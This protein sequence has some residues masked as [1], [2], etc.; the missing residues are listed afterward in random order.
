MGKSK[1]RVRRVAQLF[2][3]KGHVYPVAVGKY[4]YVRLLLYTQ[5][6]GEQSLLRD[7]LGGQTVK[8]VGSRV[9]WQLAGRTEVRQGLET[10]IA[11]LS[12]DQL[13]LA[14]QAL[15]WTRGRT[16]GERQR[17]VK[18]LKE[19]RLALKKGRP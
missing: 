13:T 5:D 8:H 18:Q 1:E 12:G 9:A 19:M 2:Q 6:D 17:A 4:L 10:I 14:R 7:V 3:E 16:Q 11:L 15:E